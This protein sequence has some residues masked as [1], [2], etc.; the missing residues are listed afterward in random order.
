MQIFV[1]FFWH[2]KCL[3]FA[4]MHFFVWV[5]FNHTCVLSS[6]NLGEQGVEFDVVYM[7]GVIFKYFLLDYIWYSHFIFHLV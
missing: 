6:L 1:R 7:L 3:R 5:M 2:L 4:K